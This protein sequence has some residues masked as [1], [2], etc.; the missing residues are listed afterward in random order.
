M[1]TAGLLQ[2]VEAPAVAGVRAG[3]DMIAAAGQLEAGWEVRVGIHSGAVVAGVVGRK[4]YVF[5]IWGDTVNIA[6]RIADQAEPGAVLVSA[7]VWRHL[8]ETFRG[9]SKGLVELKGKGSL[10]LIQCHEGP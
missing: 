8:S 6:A 5:D 4:Q 9:S 1:A 7:S 3:F 2:D 10:E